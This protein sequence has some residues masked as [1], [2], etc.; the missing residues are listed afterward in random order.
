[1]VTSGG[2]FA[3][4]IYFRVTAGLA[5]ALLYHVRGNVF[6]I[7]TFVAQNL[8]KIDEHGEQDERGVDIV[9]GN[10]ILFFLINGNSP[11]CAF[12]RWFL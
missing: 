6:D 2:E 1:M 9:T 8:V 3:T 4:H 7:S 12:A 5:N 11:P 10:A